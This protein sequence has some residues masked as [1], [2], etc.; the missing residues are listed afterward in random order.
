MSCEPACNLVVYGYANTYY[1]LIVIYY[2][3]KVIKPGSHD[4]N[5]VK[6]HKNGGPI[7]PISTCLVDTGNISFSHPGGN[8]VTFQTTGSIQIYFVFNCLY[9]I[10][11]SLL[12]TILH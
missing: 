4:I 2:S 10:I 12:I 9:V 7:I 11:L 3:L 5:L 8:M 6:F 1:S